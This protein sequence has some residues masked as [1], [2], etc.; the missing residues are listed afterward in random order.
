MTSANVAMVLKKANRSARELRLSSAPGKI[1]EQDLLEHI[2]W[3][4]MGKL[5]WIRLWICQG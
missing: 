5:I 2:S 1:P 4:F 3:C